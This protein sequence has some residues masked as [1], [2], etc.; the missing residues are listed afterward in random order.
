MEALAQLLEPSGLQT[1][2]SRRLALQVLGLA[3][4]EMQGILLSVAASL[5]AQVF[6]TRKRRALFQPTGRYRPLAWVRP[7]DRQTLSEQLG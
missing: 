7:K 3:G 4:L 6:Q 5:P 1:C 2:C